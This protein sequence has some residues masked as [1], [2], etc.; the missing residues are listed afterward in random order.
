M[1]SKI[2]RHKTVLSDSLELQ[3]RMTMNEEYR[4]FIRELLTSPCRMMEFRSE[5]GI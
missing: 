4:N 5:T 2:P 1:T 3:E